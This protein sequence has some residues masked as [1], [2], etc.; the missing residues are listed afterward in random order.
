MPGLSG[1]EIFKL[2]LSLLGCFHRFF[3]E[4]SS[5]NFWGPFLQLPNMDNTP[6]F[7]LRFYM[8]ISTYNVFS[9]LL[10][11]HHPTVPWTWPQVLSLSFS[12]TTARYTHFGSSENTPN[13]I[14]RSRAQVLLKC[15]YY[16][17]LHCQTGSYRHTLTFRAPG[18]RSS[19]RLCILTDHRDTGSSSPSGLLEARLT[20]CEEKGEVPTR[21]P[22]ESAGFIAQ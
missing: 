11:F 19:T 8:A 14:G 12:S 18:H 6:P 15:S 21:L 10:V 2:I 20:W 1:L 22:P 17:S 13:L 7:N 16:P 5:I 3:G 9:C 4:A